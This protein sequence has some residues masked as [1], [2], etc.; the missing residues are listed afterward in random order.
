LRPLSA[1]PAARRATVLALV[2]LGL[3][4]VSGALVP[5]HADAA[6]ACSLWWTGATDSSWT[7]STNWST[8]A[9]GTGSTRSPVSSD[10][11]CMSPAA[12]RTGVTYTS[13][14]RTVAGIDLSATA[15]LDPSLTIDGGR[16]TVGSSSGSV[17]STINNLTVLQG[18]T[19]QG[20]ADHLLTGTP[21]LDNNAVLDGA[22]TTTLAAGT[23]V[24]TD[25]LVLSNG[26]RLVVAGTLRHVGCYDYIYLYGGAV[27]EDAGR[28]VAASDCGMRIYA[29]NTD[30][31]LIQVNAGA[32]FEINQT[33]AETYLLQGPLDNHGTV[34]LSAGTLVAAPVSTLDGSYSLGSTAEL[35]VAAGGTLRVRPGTLSGRNAVT[36]AGGTVTVDS[37]VLIGAVDLEAGRLTGSPTIQTLDAAPGTTISGG[38]K[39]TIAV[40]GLATVDGLVVEGGTILVNKGSLSHTGCTAPIQLRT[41]AVLRNEGTVTL[42]CQSE[43]IGDG[44]VGTLVRN[45]ATGT[46]TVAMPVGVKIYSVAAGLT[47]EGRIEVTLGQLEVPQLTNFAAG[48]LTGGTYSVSGGKLVIPGNVTTNAATLTVLTPGELFNPSLTRAILGLR[49]NTGSLTVSGNLTLTST[50]LTNTGSL[51]V[52]ANTFK[53][54]TYT[55]TAG[56]TTVLSGGTLS[57]GNGPGTVVINGGT[58]TGGGRLSSLNGTG[59][60]RPAM[61]LSTLG[62]Y[63]P[64]SAATL[65]IDV[66]SGTSAGRVA[67]SGSA[68]VTGRLAIVT[69]AGFT[70]AN[71]ASWTIL[72]SSRRTGEFTQITG[73]V[74]PGDLYYAVTYG[75]STI[76]LTVKRTTLLAVA[77]ADA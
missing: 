36:V 49:T 4:V 33:A 40:G 26:R 23:T 39:V 47:N 6:V 76:T 18:G 46:I 3:S 67:A 27:L 69:K 71:G 77:D 45:T 56:T 74:L 75:T 7:V 57:G 21:T 1:R 17:A 15:S 32:R 70:P 10:V 52:K 42:A 5:V 61:T 8:N 50:G 28:V 58:L 53:P 35:R 16:L 12:T 66:N 68:T 13:L 43:L 72:T 38:G 48:T 25:G 34:Q 20:T 24:D 62:Q 63:T 44:S 73:D 31:S 19:L 30:G 14:S 55:Q 54:K 37:G 41:G 9:T 51:T 59:T 64:S 11:V 29:D 2:G 65:Q 22:G 60:T